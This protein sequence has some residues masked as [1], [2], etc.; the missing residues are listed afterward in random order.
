MGIGDIRREE[1]K[2]SSSYGTLRR[3]ESKSTPSY[4]PSYSGGM[5]A[6]RQAERTPTT[7]YGGIR[8]AERDSSPSDMARYSAD[9]SNAALSRLSGMG[10]VRQSEA[11]VSTSYGGV[12]ATERSMPTVTAPKK[13]SSK[14]SSRSSGSWMDVI[15]SQAVPDYSRIAETNTQFLNALRP[16][17]LGPMIAGAGAG[18]ALVKAGGAAI[19]EGLANLPKLVPL[20]GS[21]T[22]RIPQGVSSAVSAGQGVIGQAANRAGQAIGAGQNIISKVAQNPATIGAV[23]GGS[24]ALPTIFTPR[25]S[26]TTSSAPPTQGLDWTELDKGSSRALVPEQSFGNAMGG[27][28]SGQGTTGTGQNTMT[29]N[30]QGF[31]QD[32]YLRSLYESN[33]P[34]F[35]GQDNTMNQSPQTVAM[36]EQLPPEMFNYQQE[37]ANIQEIFT[38]LNEQNAVLMAKLSEQLLGQLDTLEADLKKQ[39]EQQGSVID[40]ATQAALK[41]IRAEVERRRQGLMEEMN[42]RG[43]LQSGIWLQEENRILNNQLTAEEKLLAGRVADIQ[44]RMT[45]A[46]MRLGQERINTMGQLAQ[47]QMQSSQWL[48]GQRLSAMQNLQSRN[49]QWNQWYQGLLTQQRQEAES[50]RRWEYEQ[51]QARAKTTAGWTGIIPEGYPGAGQ[52]TYDARMDAQNAAAKAATANRPSSTSLKQQEQAREEQWNREIDTFLASNMNKFASKNDLVNALRQEYSEIVRRW[53]SEGWAAIMAEVDSY[54]R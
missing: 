18:G 39:Y 23:A 51:E 7:S 33:R 20:L 15:A 37:V 27:T 6:V 38:G 25:T 46:L 28:Y 43:L 26:S 47:N 49:D 2:K 34:G 8:A 5:G 3:E 12:R 13:K 44:N 41:E 4:V 9:S 42:R 16:S 30:A 14:S 54:W 36:P 53:G 31:N 22:Q 17:N 19:K 32:A 1:R 52:P 24:V 48:Q 35:L 10:A 50:K 29:P 40:P 11:P 21:A 45:D